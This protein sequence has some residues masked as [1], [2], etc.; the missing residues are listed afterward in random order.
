[1]QEGIRIHLQP[2]DRKPR[3]G[4]EPCAARFVA[5]ADR[6]HRDAG[7]LQLRQ[8]RHQGLGVLEAVEIPQLAQQQHQAAVTP[9]HPGHPR[10]AFEQGSGAGHRQGDSQGSTMLEDA[11]VT[12]LGPPVGAEAPEQRP[13]RLRLSDVEH[14]RLT[15]VLLRS[16]W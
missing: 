16:L 10:Q 5:D 3:E 13:W 9:F 6:Q 8:H 15:S 12:D 1:M 2:L 7:G 11:E 14:R 4:A